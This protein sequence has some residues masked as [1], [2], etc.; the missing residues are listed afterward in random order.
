M[1][2]SSPYFL[3]RFK[4]VVLIYFWLGWGFT[5]GDSSLVLV[6][7][8]YSLVAVLGLHLVV[9]SLIEELP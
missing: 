5:A 9:P 3:F 7:K 6:N 1:P 2:R 8:G 4:T